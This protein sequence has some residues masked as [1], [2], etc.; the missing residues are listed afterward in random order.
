MAQTVRVTPLGL[1][2]VYIAPAGT[3]L[4]SMDWIHLADNLEGTV[5]LTQDDPTLTEIYVEESDLPIESN[6]KAG[7]RKFNSS[8]PDLSHGVLQTLFWGNLEASRA[9]AATQ[10]GE[11][12]TRFEMPDSSQAVYYAFKFVP[13]SGAKAFIFTKGKVAA[14]INGNFSKT[15]SMNVD[16]VVT[17]LKSDVTGQAGFYIDLPKGVNPGYLLGDT[18]ADNALATLIAVADG[19]LS[20]TVDGGTPEVNNAIDF[21][22]DTT[23]AEVIAT[24]NAAFT[25]DAK[26]STWSL[27]AEEFRVRVTSDSTGVG[28]TIALTDGTGT[29]I[30]G[31][32][33]LNMSG[34]TPVPGS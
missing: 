14:K 19:S 28:S 34:S 27:D 13:N 24:L 16:L 2:G 17:S 22:G 20:L 9:T 23:W 7:V 29:A 5:S 8:I 3:S 33:M 18:L 11:D 31:A 12:V 30:R 26:D 1:Y 15:E 25:G 32:T 4:D 21:T 10:D 6:E